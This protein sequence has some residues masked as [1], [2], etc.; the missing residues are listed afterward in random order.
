MSVDVNAFRVKVLMNIP[1]DL[2]DWVTSHYNVNNSKYY[3][4]HL[5]NSPH[6][7]GLTT[8]DWSIYNRFLEATIQPEHSAEIFQKLANE[9]D[10]EKIGD[11]VAHYYAHSD[12]YWLWDGCHR[13]IITKA[14]NK[15]GGGIPIKNAKFH[16]FPCIIEKIHDML[17]KTTESRFY[18]GWTNRT[19][20]GY[21]SFDMF[22][23][24]IQGQR[25]PVQRFEIIKQHY[26]FTGKHVLDLGCNTGGML[27]H[28]PEIAKGIGLDYDQSCLDA[29]KFIH[30]HFHLLAPM[31]FKLQ[32]LNEFRCVDLYPEGSKRPDIVFLLSLGS[33]V[34]NW[35]ALYTDVY[36]YTDTI[37]LEINNSGEGVPQLALFES[38]GA[39]VKCISEAS[40]DDITGNQARKTYLIYKPSL[41]PLTTA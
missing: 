35:Q 8:G 1:D 28:I 37:L 29:A 30:Y 36:N 4:L 5:E 17:R 10:P 12:Y 20:F 33:W 24:H 40:L 31:E 11:I 27:I 13:V 23:V 18:N 6:Y 38:L 32:D 19:E 21:H 41:P 3:I 34:K 26:D 22:N 15:N 2:K 39:E 9:W 14:L 25:N 16:Y 7:H